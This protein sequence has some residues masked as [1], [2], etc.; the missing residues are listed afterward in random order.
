MVEIAVVGLIAGLGRNHEEGHVAQG[1]QADGERVG[2]GAPHRHG[3]H[4]LYAD[5]VVEQSQAVSVD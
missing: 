3:V 4:S 1:K 2:Y 5:A